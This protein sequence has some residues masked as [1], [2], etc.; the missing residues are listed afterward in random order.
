MPRY[1][2][3]VRDDGELL[4]DFEGEE[5]E[6]LENARMHAIEGARGILSDAV[7]KGEAA[8]LNR[9]VEVTTAMVGR[10]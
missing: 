2:F 4:E 8:N 3:H 10:S 5:C 9:Q 6:S 7:L 1:Y